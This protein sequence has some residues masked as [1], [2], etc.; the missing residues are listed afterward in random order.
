MAGRPPNCRP[1]VTKPPRTLKVPAK[2]A[3]RSTRA[4][5]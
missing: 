1:I 3:P 2:R 4:P 5:R